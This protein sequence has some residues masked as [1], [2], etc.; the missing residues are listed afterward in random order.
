MKKTHS[1]NC[2]CGDCTSNDPYINHLRSQFGKNANFS[3]TVNGGVSPFGFNEYD[4]LAGME[5]E[6]WLGGSTSTKPQSAD[7][8]KILGDA[9][10]TAVGGIIQA[11]KEGQILPPLLDKVAGLGIKTEQAAYNAAQGKAQSEIGKNVLKFAPYIVGGIVAIVLLF[12][13]IKR[14]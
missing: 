5:D 2:L 10:G 1:P 13:F 6:P 14:K 12:L 4:H 8:K 7:L 11:K 3:N 9:L